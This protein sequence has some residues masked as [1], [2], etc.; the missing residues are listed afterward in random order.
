MR[1]ALRVRWGR[2]GRWSCIK[3]VNMVIYGSVFC[4]LLDVSSLDKLLYPFKAGKY[5]LLYRLQVFYFLL[6]KALLF[7]PNALQS[8]PEAQELQECKELFCSNGYILITQLG[9][10]T[11]ATCPTHKTFSHWRWFGNVSMCIQAD[12]NSRRIECTLND[13]K[14]HFISTLSLSNNP[15]VS[16]EKHDSHVVMDDPLPDLSLYVVVK[17]CF[18]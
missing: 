11:Y 4:L 2:V 7:P 12:W 16:G 1:G 13:F 15:L 17:L 18:T 10:Y 14:L 8:S 5:C 6:Q 3:A 9:M